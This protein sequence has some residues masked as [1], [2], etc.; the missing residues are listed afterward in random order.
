MSNTSTIHI[1]T[2]STNIGP[3]KNKPDILTPTIKTTCDTHPPT[4]DRSETFT[5]PN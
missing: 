5:T 4:T 2:M 3:I 1:T